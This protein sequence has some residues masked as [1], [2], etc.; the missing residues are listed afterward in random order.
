MQR[1]RL[2]KRSTLVFPVLLL[3]SSFR[4]ETVKKRLTTSHAG[5]TGL[6]L[7]PSFYSVK[8]YRENSSRSLFGPHRKGF[9]GKELA[10]GYCLE[11]A[12]EK[13]DQSKSE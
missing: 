4:E 11:M 6:K 3:L 1:M 5:L 9:S 13:R 10:G 8:Q 7:V 12:V 2:E